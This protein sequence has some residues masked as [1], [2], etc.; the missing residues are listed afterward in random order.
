MQSHPSVRF[1]LA[2]F[3]LF[4]TACSGGVSQIGSRPTPVPTATTAPMAAWVNGEGILLSEYQGETLRLLAA[5][6]ELEMEMDAAQQKEKVLN[7]LI[8]QTLLAQNASLQGHFITDADLQAKLDELVT[9]VGGSEKLQE[10]MAKYQYDDASLRYALRRNL[11]AAWMRDQIIAG[12]EEVADQA[13]VRQIRVD[14]QTEAQEILQQLQTGSD[15]ETLAWQYDPITGGDL[16][17]F[18]RGYLFQPEVDEAAFALQ[19]GQTS[20]II[21]TDIGF[22]IILLIERDASHILTPDAR[23]FLQHQALEQWLAQKKS[24]STIEIL[25]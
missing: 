8:V 23:Q 11:A 19:P 5:L 25:V 24:E 16:G 4:L 15:F 18:P 10:W 7:E 22:H 14:S 1:I 6:Q 3:L 21:E 13:H 20:A 9:E 17:W 2:L 12:V